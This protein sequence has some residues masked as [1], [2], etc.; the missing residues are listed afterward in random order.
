[1]RFGEKAAFFAGFRAV[2]DLET[3]PDE[4]AILM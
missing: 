1:V 4:S 3:A 2:S